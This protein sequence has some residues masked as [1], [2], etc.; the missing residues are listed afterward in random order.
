MDI[1]SSGIFA[2][3]KSGGGL[4]RGLFSA[5]SAAPAAAGAT[6]GTKIPGVPA[7]IISRREVGVY[8]NDFI[9]NADILDWR[10]TAVVGGA[11]DILADYVNGAMR[12]VHDG[13]ANQGPNVMFDDASV[14][15]AASF[16]T[17]TADKVIAFEAAVEID[18]VSSC[19]WYVGIAEPDSTFM[20]ADGSIGSVGADNHAGF[21][22]VVT[23]AGVPNMSVNA[24]TGTTQA[25]AL[26]SG[27]DFSGNTLSGSISDG[28]KHRYGIRIEGTQ[29]VEF[30]LDG[31]LVHVVV[32]TAAYDTNMTIHFDLIDGGNTET[33]D[34]DYVMVAQTR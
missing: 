14:D 2:D 16:I 19:D 30:Y 27:V 9:G 10:V 15:N 18:D 25:T 20:G 21:H 1:R 33:L 8:F 34:V 4:F 3:V 29:H 31:N 7:D 26:G 22:H 5:G 11:A 6:H 32:P 17:A 13:T 23:N 12:L 28:T 24:A